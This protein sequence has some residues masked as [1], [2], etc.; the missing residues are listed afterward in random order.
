MSA[1]AQDLRA[2]VRG[3]VAVASNVLRRGHEDPGVSYGGE[4]AAAPR[5]PRASS[6]R[7]SEMSVVVVVWEEGSV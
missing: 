5:T 6:G 2:V 4:R 3:L 1:R 7:C